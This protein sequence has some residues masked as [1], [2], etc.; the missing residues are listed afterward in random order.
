MVAFHAEAS[1]QWARAVESWLAAADLALARFA[2]ADAERMLD[3]GLLAAE[4]VSDPDEPTGRWCCSPGPGPRVPLAV[5]AAPTRTSRGRWRS[6]RDAGSRRLQMLLHRELGGD[7]TIGMGRPIATCVPHLE[8]SLGLARELGDRVMEAGA[9]GR[10]AVLSC[11]RL[12]IVEGQALAAAAVEAARG[13]DDERALVVALDGLKNGYAYTGE[14]VRLAGVLDELMPL[15]ARNAD[16]F[17]LQWTTFE[18]GLVPLAAGDWPAA[19]ALVEEALALNRRSGRPSFESFFIANLGWIERLAGRHDDAVGQGRRSLEAPSGSA[20]AWWDAIAVGMLATTLLEGSADG[21]TLDADVVRMLKRG[22]TAA[23]RNGAESY[24]LRCLAPLAL[25]TGSED[26]LQ[27]ADRMLAGAHFPPGV[28][29]LHGIDV[30]LVIARAWLAAGDAARAG[31]VLE[32]MLLAGE[33]G[34]LVGRAGGVRSG[35]AGGYSSSDSRAAA[36]RCPPPCTGR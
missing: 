35:R 29:W 30:Y 31:A 22:L 33:T 16:L 4:R 24:R 18:A 8:A 21:S 5:P 11:S 15:L 19:R 27:Q 34:R 9:L 14:L 17:L 2:A 13:S 7:A 10:L 12:A 23:D 32:P 3:R 36:S 25:A 28:A 20:H 6:P 26:Y 1:E